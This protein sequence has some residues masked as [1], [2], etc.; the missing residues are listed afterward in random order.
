MSIKQFRVFGILSSVKC[1][2]GFS[3]NRFSNKGYVGKVD[4]DNHNKASLKKNFVY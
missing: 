1:P 2:F 3:D 4:V